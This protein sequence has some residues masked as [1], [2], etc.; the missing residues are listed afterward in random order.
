[1]KF[2]TRHILA[3][4]V[5][6]VIVG[7]GAHQLAAQRRPALTLTHLFT[8]PD[9][10]THAGSTEVNLTPSTTY[11]GTEQS[12]LVKV[13]GAQFLRL[14]LGNVL[15]WHNAGRRQYVV[16]LSGRGEV[17]LITGEKILLTPG[18]MVLA[19]DVTGKGHITRST[20]SEDLV[21]LIVPL[22]AQ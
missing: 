12:E 9:G 11:T 4:L 6:C 1:M 10:Q 13:S 15:D 21:L 3:A 14:P 8:G 5:G 19:E 2:F 16:T 20:G 7:M 17:E 22:A 18:R